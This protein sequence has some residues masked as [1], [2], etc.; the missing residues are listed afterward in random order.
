MT[1][2]QT[3]SLKFVLLVVCCLWVG[4]AAGADD[5][6]VSKPDNQSVNKPDSKPANP[7]VEHTPIRSTV[8]G[9]HSYVPER[10]SLININVTNPGDAPRDIVSATYFDGEPTLQ[11]A[12]R[13]WLPPRSRLR[14]WVP[15]LV[16]RLA[17]D[18]S[19]TLPYH[20]LVYDADKSREVLLK[21]DTGL[22]LHS[23]ILAAQAESFV[24]GFID[25]PSGLPAVDAGAAYNLIVACRR[26][27]NHSRRATNLAEHLFAPDEFSLQPF[28]QIVISCDRALGD[29][30]GLAAV[31]RWVYGGGRLW[32]MLNQVDPQVLE[33]IVGDGFACHV[34]D[35]VGLTNVQIDPTSRN[36]GSG[37]AEVEYEQPIDFLRV[38]VDDREVDVA[39]TV[40]GW[41]A[42]FTK[43]YGRGLVVVTTLAPRAWYR[44]MTPEEVVAQRQAYARANRGPVTDLQDSLFA[45]LPPMHVLASAMEQQ[46]EHKTNDFEQTLASFAT[47]YIGYAIPSRG[48][49]GGLLTGFGCLVLA[50]GSW[51]WRRQALEHLGWVGPGLGVCT[52]IALVAVG[53]RNRYQLEPSVVAAVQV[54]EAL[55][56]ADDANV[57]GGL[58]FFTREST[59]WKIQTH[60]G[61]RLTPEMSGLEGTTRRMVWNDL[62]DWTWEHL[63]L[64]TPQRTAR[65]RQSLTPPARFEARGTFASSGVT[66]RLSGGNPARLSEVVLATRDGRIGVDVRADGTFVAAAD[67]VF[68][69]DQYVEAGFLGDEQDRRRRAYSEVLRK[70]IGED[71]S[72][73]P[74]LMGWTD[75]PR[76]GFEFDEGRQRLGAS[77]VVVPVTLDRPAAGTDITI[78]LPLL[79]F[80]IVNLPFGD[81]KTP[82]SPVWSALRREWQER[83]ELS[84]FWMKFQIP[85]ALLP[86]DVVGGR[87]TVQVTGPVTQME[88]FG[89]S[90]DAAGNPT[91]TSPPVSIERWN[92]PVGSH[93]F[94]L[95]DRSLL[96]LAAG[97]G[98]LLGLTAGDPERKPDVEVKSTPPL[99][100]NPSMNPIADIQPGPKTELEEFK[101]SPWQIVHLGLELTAR[102][103]AVPPAGA[104]DAGRNK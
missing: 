18:G 13:M 32:V 70:I 4:A 16:P 54:I 102:T 91:G 3:H 79:P 8:G 99:N 49:I 96:H 101:S 7:R 62:G 95:A 34:V 65:Y 46:T 2:I 15:V 55:P 104:S 73:P 6:P 61:G 40:N 57:T 82:S 38:V 36:S 10:W 31:R 23:G 63:Q 24:T 22:M 72:G 41:P 26:D 100:P 87:L 21:D 78:P 59:D 93:A 71:W 51:L 81:G 77:L 44:L 37:A 30:A 12:R 14:T 75:E 94:E 92:N 60:S 9:M 29:P 19:P 50:G 25:D 42:A 66:G 68:S 98:L 83:R 27:Q 89:L 28:N 85:P 76:A 33:A 84:T 103:P 20:S 47:E 80:R 39:Y 64:D 43:R 1:S 35:R 53:V 74:L 58:A 45:V 90:T 97:G 11:Y 52:A 69:S 48:L 67:R 5:K 88:L 17:D 86:V 56:G